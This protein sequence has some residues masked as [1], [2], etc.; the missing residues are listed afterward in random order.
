LQIGNDLDD[1]QARG[2][3]DVNRLHGGVSRLRL[4]RR[5]GGCAQRERVVTR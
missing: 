5:Q 4:R 3:C 2:R 1:S